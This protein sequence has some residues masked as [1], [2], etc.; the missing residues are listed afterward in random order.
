ML[1]SDVVPR[2]TIIL[3]IFMNDFDGLP[4]HSSYSNCVFPSPLF[5][6]AA[7][8]SCGVLGLSKFP[9]RGLFT[10]ATCITFLES[11]SLSVDSIY[12]RQLLVSNLC[13]FLFFLF[14]C[15][16][17]WKYWYQCDNALNSWNTPSERVCKSI[18]FIVIG[19]IGIA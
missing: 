9:F 1:T 11:Q 5:S 14:F 2:I 6:L 7:S 4:F 18:L 3:A 13:F 10:V 15:K 19:I 12:T 16:N 17:T 8:G